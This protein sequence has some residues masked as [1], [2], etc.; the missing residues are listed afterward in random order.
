[1]PDFARETQPRKKRKKKRER[2]RKPTSVVVGAA[3]WPRAAELGVV[4]LEQRDDMLDVGGEVVAGRGGLADA[5]GQRGQAQAV[6][7]GRGGR[8]L[9]RAA[10]ARRAAFA[11]SL[12]RLAR[13]ARLWLCLY[14]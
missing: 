12:G 6:V 3:V 5:E 7:G 8:R 13:A 11:A 2:E 10:A 9:G 1:M 14:N 4:L